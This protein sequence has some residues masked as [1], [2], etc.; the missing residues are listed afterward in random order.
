MKT[1]DSLKSTTNHTILERTEINIAVTKR[2]SRRRI[3]T[4]TNRRYSLKLIKSV[5]ESAVGDIR[6]QISDI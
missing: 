3:S 2:P 6:M 5:E 4:N 1:L